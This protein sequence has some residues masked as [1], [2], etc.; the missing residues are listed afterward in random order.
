MVKHLKV[1]KYYDHA[2]LSVKFSFAFYA[3]IG[4]LNY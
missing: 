4:S 2:W 1:S 3:F